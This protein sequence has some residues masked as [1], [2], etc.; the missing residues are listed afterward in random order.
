MLTGLGS[1]E[2]KV[3]QKAIVASE[4]SKIMDGFSIMIVEH[5]RERDNIDG[6]VVM[7]N[8]ELK[9]MDAPNEL[10]DLVASRRTRK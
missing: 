9:K 2:S 3:V 4:I 8:E 6:T 5:R 7:S 1:D 10:T